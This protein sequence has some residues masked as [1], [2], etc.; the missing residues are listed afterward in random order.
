MWFL[1]GVAVNAE[2]VR[3]IRYRFGWSRAEMARSMNCDV[4]QV[5]AWETGRIEPSAA[6]RAQLTLFIA[7][8]ETNSQR[9]Q[10]R[11]IAELIMETSGLDQIHDSQVDRMTK[12]R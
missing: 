10:R 2:M 5:L 12:P 6:A 9:V 11:P 7:Q 8:A 4:G 3:Q 1:I